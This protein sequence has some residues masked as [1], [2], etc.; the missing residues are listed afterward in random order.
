MCYVGGPSQRRMMRI[1]GDINHRVR[2]EKC[3]CKT[4]KEMI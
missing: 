3:F 2:I 1:G 4:R